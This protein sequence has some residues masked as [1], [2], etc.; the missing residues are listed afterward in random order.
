[1]KCDIC[2]KTYINKTSLELHIKSFHKKITNVTCHIC[3]KIFITKYILQ[4]H[5][6][7]IHNKSEVK[8]ALCSKIL[9]DDNLK[10]H[11]YSIH[12]I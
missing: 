11:M 9:E 6:N 7:K 3:N 10:Y 12:K 5:I 4:T 2:D 1:M 8:C